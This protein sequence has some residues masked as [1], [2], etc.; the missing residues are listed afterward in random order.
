MSTSP[1]RHRLVRAGI[2][3]GLA[4]TMLIAVATPASAADAPAPQPTSASVLTPLL[5]ILEFGDFVG[6]PLA[7]NLITSLASTGAGQA[8]LS[9]AASPFVT[10]INDTCA[11]LSAKGST[12]LEQ[13]IDQ[14]KALV[15]INPALD[16]VVEQLS[17]GATNVGTNDSDAVA[18][19][20]PTIAGL[21]NTVSFFEGG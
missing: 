4:T 18:P 8:N 7:C 3:G 13:A 20:G 16:P 6:L 5:H 12:Y 17:T 14:S 21:G 15:F 1:L 10:Q 11:E 9:D 2:A 19:F